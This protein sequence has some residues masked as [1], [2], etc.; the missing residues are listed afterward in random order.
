MNKSKRNADVITHK[1]R[2]ASTKVTNHSLEVASK[3]KR[4]KEKM[5]KRWKTKAMTAKRQTTRRGISLSSEKEENYE[6]DTKDEI[7]LD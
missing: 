1:L 5:V 4:K 6:N 3:E 7:D 2:P